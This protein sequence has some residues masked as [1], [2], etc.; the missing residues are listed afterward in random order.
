MVSNQMYNG[1]NILSNGVNNMKNK[2]KMQT[3][4][5]S[6]LS[7]NVGN[8]PVRSSQKSILR[9][10]VAGVFAAIVLVVTWIL[11][12]P[13]SGGGGY[14]NLG[15]G[16]VL[17]ASYLLGPIAFFPAA[18]GSALA[19]LLVAGCAVY[20]PFTFVIKGM[21]GLTAGLILRNDK[22][23][24]VQRIAAFVIAETIMIVGYSITEG[25]LTR[26]SAAAFA[27]IFPNLLQAAAG[28]AIAMLLSSLLGKLRQT[29]RSKMN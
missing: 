15:D 3:H 10:T 8:K 20:S 16:V 29:M 17:I 12:I 22:V 2:G 14:L 11:P 5:D 26:S 4:N 19:D 23:T 27:S 6:I 13:I 18:I 21:M 7:Q 9:I 1:N 24:V 25:I 28:I